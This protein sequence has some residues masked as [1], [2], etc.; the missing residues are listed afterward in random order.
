MSA[1]DTRKMTETDA[2]L[3]VV[4]CYAST[5]QG[6]RTALVGERRP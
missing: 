2:T 4:A 6:I 3:D 5:S 1:P